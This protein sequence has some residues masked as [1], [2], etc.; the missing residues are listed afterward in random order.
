[1]VEKKFDLGSLKITVST[2]AEIA[3][4]KPPT[5]DMW[6][7]RGLVSPPYLHIGTKRYWLAKDIDS[8]LTQIKNR[9]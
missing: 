2:L 1:M 3:G 9:K 6:I 8:L 5:I 7:A 4:T